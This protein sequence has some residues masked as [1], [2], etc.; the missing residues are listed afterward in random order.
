MGCRGYSRCRCF[1]CCPHTWFLCEW[2]TS[3]ERSTMEREQSLV[4]TPFFSLSPSSRQP[5]DALLTVWMGAHSDNR[6]HSGRRERNFI[7]K[8]GQREELSGRRRSS[9]TSPKGRWSVIRPQRS[10]PLNQRQ[11]QLW[12]LT[13]GEQVPLLATCGPNLTLCT[14][15]H[16]KLGRWHRRISKPKTTE[17]GQSWLLV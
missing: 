8:S 3:A 17:V 15:I 2:R 10:S 5:R 9:K 13:S 14:N 4:S 16:T 11:F 12:M 1:L 7:Q 6:S